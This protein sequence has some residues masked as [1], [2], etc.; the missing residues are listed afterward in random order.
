MPALTDPRR[1]RACQLRANGGGILE[2]YNAAGFD[3]QAP[4]ATIFFRK[5]AILA[6]V[7]EIQADRWAAERQVADRA[8][9]KSSLKESWII[10]RA[11]YVVE[12][13]LRGN[14]IRG[15]DGMPTGQ[16]DGKSNLR[17]ATDALRL[18][19]D[20]KGM[21][22]QRH[23][24]GGPGDFARMTDDELNGALV[25]QAQA[26]GL[27]EEAIAGLL[28]HQTDKDEAAE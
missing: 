22:I 15:P 12:L 14:P 27:P 8:V 10:E 3:G 1:E 24:I 6:R 17:A 21:R 25:Q 23:E 2:S 13:A 18:C 19:S 7:A 26:L 4:T 11:K 5:P 16:F 28:T 9:E 20:F